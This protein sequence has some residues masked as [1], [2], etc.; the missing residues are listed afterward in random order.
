MFPV[1]EK[2]GPVRQRVAALQKQAA[3]AEVQGEIGGI[4][5]RA[6]LDAELDEGLVR[7]TNL[8]KEMQQQAILAKL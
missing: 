7:R 6:V 5:L 3:P 4:A 1:V 2:P 8:R